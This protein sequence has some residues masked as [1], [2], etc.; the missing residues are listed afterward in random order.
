[1]SDKPLILNAISR[2]PSLYETVSQQLM[3][4]IRDANLAP[5][6]KIPSER[7][8]G[9]RFG[10]SRTVIREAIRHLAAKGVL[11]ARSGS[12][13]VIANFGHEGVSESLALFLQ[14][15]GPLD[16]DKIHEVRDCLELRAVQLATTRA[17]GEQIAEI[18]AICESMS[19]TEG[20]PETSA[21]ADLAFHRAI[22]EATG[23]ELFLV[24]VDSVGDVLLD[25]RR[26][27][28]VDPRRVDVALKAHRKVVRALQ[29][30]D[31]PAAI[32]AM[33]EHLD[34]SFVAFSKMVH[35]EK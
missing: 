3:V 29:A 13:V 16:P 31:E 7:D 4:A 22:A 28:L 10:V 15:R 34:E 25:I 11:E 2:N 5:G 9:E 24:L 17:S 35:S 26:A 19:T 23:N 32:D 6:D 14:Q 27:T 30:R 8:L 18:H 21:Q 20:D 1:M 12:G 33:R